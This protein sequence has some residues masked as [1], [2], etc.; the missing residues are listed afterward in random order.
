M[1]VRNPRGRWEDAVW[2]DAIDLLQIKNWKAAT[3]NG[4]VWRKK[5]QEAMGQKWA[6]AP[7]KKER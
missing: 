6:I 7:L 2:R 4:E 1:P 3:R 5:I